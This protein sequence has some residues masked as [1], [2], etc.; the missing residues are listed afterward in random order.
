MKAIQI[1][2]DRIQLLRNL[3]T[4]VID[5]RSSNKISKFLF[6]ANKNET[7]RIR[8]YY[9]IAIAITGESDTYVPDD[10]NNSELVIDLIR[11][12]EKHIHKQESLRRLCVYATALN[13]NDKVSQ[14]FENYVLLNDKEQC[15]LLISEERRRRAQLEITR[16]EL[17][18]KSAQ[19]RF[20]KNVSEILIHLRANMD[21]DGRPIHRD[22][23]IGIINKHLKMLYA[24]DEILE[25]YKRFL[26]TAAY[27]VFLKMLERKL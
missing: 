15:V 18:A 12:L 7:V 11:Y 26:D 13:F 3:K 19:N 17:L 1:V 8:N 27:N 5:I 22:V 25:A 14:E 2:S 10:L 20:E 24:K 6:N 4:S 23:N 16:A 21:S 9:H